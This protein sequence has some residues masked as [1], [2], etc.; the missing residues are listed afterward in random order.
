MTFW[1]PHSLV[2]NTLVRKRQ[3]WR[4]ELRAGQKFHGN[5]LAATKNRPAIDAGKLGMSHKQHGRNSAV[6]KSNDP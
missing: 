4:L 6:E 2:R 3:G 1:F 5:R